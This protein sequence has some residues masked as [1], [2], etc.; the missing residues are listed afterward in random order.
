MRGDDKSIPINGD[1]RAHANVNRDDDLDHLARIVES[2][3]ALISEAVRRY[4]PGSSLFYD[5]AQQVFLLFV[6]GVR[7]KNWDPDQNP[8]GL[9]YAIA[10]NV[11]QNMWTKEQKNSPEALQKIGE[12]FL[13]ARNRLEG[14]DDTH[15]ENEFYQER[16]TAL[17]ACMNKLNPKSLE[18][19]DLHYCQGIK[20]DEIGRKYD[21]KSVTIR[22]IF[23]RLRAKLRDC[24][25]R[26]TRNS[27][28]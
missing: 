25:E 2:R 23:S 1:G 13:R 9:L 27:E 22:Q 4:A 15:R 10:R 21:I 20:L 11:S 19:L 18:F 14:S 12:L 8:D 28:Q 5:V 6:E 16:L 26:S 24:I 7:Q 17:R 3:Y